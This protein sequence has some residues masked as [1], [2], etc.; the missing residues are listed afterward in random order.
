[1]KAQIYKWL[2]ELAAQFIEGASDAFLI[3]AGGNAVTQSTAATAAVQISPREIL[4]SVVLG[5]LIYA[6]SY[7]K[8]NPLPGHGEPRPAVSDKQ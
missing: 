2:N 5:G 7:L 4:V 1:M 6:A 8:H 3:V